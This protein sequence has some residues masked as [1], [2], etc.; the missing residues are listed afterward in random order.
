MDF[1]PYSLLSQGW[2]IAPMAT[3][4][5]YRVHNCPKSFPN[6][7]RYWIIMNLLDIPNLL[8]S[9]ISSMNALASYA[10]HNVFY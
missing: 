4:R 3:S 10:L 5:C 9:R 2:R 6:K 7:V 8:V 1:S